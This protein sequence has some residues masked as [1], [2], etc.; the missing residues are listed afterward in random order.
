MNIMKPWEGYL[1]PFRVFGNLYFVGTVPASTHVIDTGEGL[2][3]MDCGYQ[4]SLYIVME[5]MHRIGLEPSDL[6]YLLVT[7]GHIDHCG[8]AEALRHLTGC[9]ILIG[10][11][12]RLYVNGTLD[13]TYAAELNLKFIPFEP[14][15]LLYDNDCITLGNTTVRCMASPG[16]TPGTMS[17][18]FNVTDGTKTYRAGLHGGMGTNTLSQAFLNKYHLPYDC[19]A[20]FIRSM[21]R[22][23]EED[24]DIFLGNHAEH[25]HTIEKAGRVRN[26]DLEAFVDP[27]EWK[28]YTAW[29]IQNLEDMLQKETAGKV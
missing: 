16:H 7:H 28:P 10:E 25:N 14:D 27:T 1:E 13:L 18:F 9:K 3:M 29:C 11:P 15:G 21:H 6:R 8:A 17:F 4:E 20:D 2:I 12:D 24:V 19:R 22:L 26:G 5:N 23:Q